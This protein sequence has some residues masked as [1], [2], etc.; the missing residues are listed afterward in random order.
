MN[1]TAQKATMA[2]MQRMTVNVLMSVSGTSGLQVGT[3]LLPRSPSMQRGPL[4]RTEQQLI[5][6]GGGERQLRFERLTC[7]LRAR[8]VASGNGRVRLR[9]ETQDSFGTT[10]QF[11][12]RGVVRTQR[13]L[14]P[15]RGGEFRQV[16]VEPAGFV[17][18]GGHPG[19]LTEKRDIRDGTNSVCAGP[20]RFNSPNRSRI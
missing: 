4:G 19:L 20:L 8:F 11:A 14:I 12:H 1:R 2:Q 5:D 17:V 18:T 9:G 16:G 15:F 7:G 10:L 13:R 3:V 6:Q